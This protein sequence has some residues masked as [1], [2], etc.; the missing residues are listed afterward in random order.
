MTIFAVVLL[1]V[2]FNVPLTGATWSIV[3]LDKDTGRIGVASNTC[4]ALPAFYSRFLEDTFVYVPG[5]GAVVA[6][7]WYTDVSLLKEAR[8]LIENGTTGEELLQTFAE[9]KRCFDPFRAIPEVQCPANNSENIQLV[10]VL[11]YGI[12]LAEDANGTTYTGSALDELY[13]EFG[14][15]QTEQTGMVGRVDN[16]QFAVQGNIVEEGTVAATFGNFTSGPSLSQQLLTALAAGAKSGYGDAR[17][18]RDEAYS[19]KTAL[20]GYLRVI[21]R[22]GRLSVNVTVISDEDD[23]RDVVD[24]MQDLLYRASNVA[25]SC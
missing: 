14:T 1:F 9:E 24:V 13:S 5:K 17:C 2:A 18:I 6:Q 25:E 20:I 8:S 12:V 4:I 16:I 10:D 21:E 19:P 11:Q 3:A 23:D 15:L 7:A 22:S